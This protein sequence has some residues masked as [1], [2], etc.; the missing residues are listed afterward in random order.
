MKKIIYAIC[1]ALLCFSVAA[2]AQPVDE[3]EV[4]DPIVQQYLDMQENG[5]SGGE[6]AS[7]Y[8]KQE[9][10]YPDPKRPKAATQEQIQAAIDK[11]AEHATQE[12]VDESNDTFKYGVEDQ[13][14]SAL[15]TLI[16]EEDPRFVEAV[17]DLFSETKS[18]VVKQKVLAYFTKLKDPCL[19]DFAVG[20]INDPYDEKKAIVSACFSYVSAVKSTAA[21]PGVVDLLD[22][23]EEDYFN[24]ALSCLGDVG[25]DEEAVFIAEYLDRSDLTTAQRQQLMKVLGKLKAVQTYDK[26]VEIVQNE[27]EDSYVRMYAAEAIGAMQ[28]D[29]A[30]EILADLFETDDA[31]LR[32]YVIKGL[33]NFTDKMATDII[34]QA[35]RDSQ[36]KVRLEAIN[37]VQQQELKSAV[38]YLI[39]R[40]KDK[41]EQQQVKDK[42]YTVLADFN[43]K[44][45]N[46]YLVSL[47]KDKRLGDNTKAKVAAAL[48]KNG[49]AGT[50][51]IIELARDTLKNDIH[52]NLRYSLGKEFA[53]YGRAEYEGICSEYLANKDVAT[54]GT[55]I[56]IYAKGKYSSL[57]PQIEQIARNGKKNNA[58]A[59]KARK[60]L[61]MAE[62]DEERPE[63]TE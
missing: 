38:P 58:N 26:L 8:V 37:S 21:V 49:N 36:Y 18:S 4:I 41:G 48:L 12:Y 1:P 14:C 10:I 3:P 20:V 46:D 60:I 11:N 54:Q 15:D 23:E 31:N 55:G 40:C 2:F 6:G 5:D 13:I 44:E 17:Y 33:S 9:K 27:D 59:K 28:M 32:V 30:E 25:G 45:G 42:C 50:S 35:L 53:K 34:I 57:T 24:S 43:T 51:E 61:G 29:N 39:Y 16:S 62:E 22:K 7:Q 19:E 56:D 47:I 63:A 52:K